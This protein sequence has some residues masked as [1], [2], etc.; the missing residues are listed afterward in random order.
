MTLILAA[1]AVP[2]ILIAGDS[3]GTDLAGG[4]DLGH[5]AFVHALRDKHNCTFKATN[6][7]VP[8]SLSPDWVRQPRIERGT[9]TPRLARTL[10]F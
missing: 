4:T 3:W 7:A 9:F 6:I 8:G 2:K 1:M 5:S 10:P